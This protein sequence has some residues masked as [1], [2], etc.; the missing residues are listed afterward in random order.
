MHFMQGIRLIILVVWIL[1]L[2][3]CANGDDDAIERASKSPS[4]FVDRVLDYDQF[5]QAM[6]NKSVDSATPTG[7][8]MIYA[9]G[10]KNY[11]MNNTAPKQNVVK[12]QYKL[13]ADIVSL[14][15]LDN[16]NGV[17]QLVMRDCSGSSHSN[18]DAVANNLSGVALNTLSTSISSISRNFFAL[19][20]GP[21]DLSLAPDEQA[22]LQSY[23]DQPIEVTIVNNN[24]MQFPD[25]FH[26][27]ANSNNFSYHFTGRKI[28]QDLTANLGGF[29][30]NKNPNNEQRNTDCFNLVNAEVS[31]TNSSAS[32]SI[33]R[34]YNVQ[35]YQAYSMASETS[36]GYLL[37]YEG[38]GPYD[39]FINGEKY[40]F[41]FYEKLNYMDS[42][43]STAIESSNGNIIQAKTKFDYDLGYAIEFIGSPGTKYELNGTIA[44]KFP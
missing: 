19:R 16:G 26:Y 1:L 38:T 30:S 31:D 43:G 3:A 28:S 37:A 4:H 27:A 10:S 21:F 2:L 5:D 9:F 8:W 20:D 7:I 14:Y 40:H 25:V 13:L 35:A 32:A 6:L 41:D 29:V 24:T 17:N 18:I 11:N 33:Q 22:I 34:I 39:K 36:L 15:V 23:L 44:A 42:A 12:Y